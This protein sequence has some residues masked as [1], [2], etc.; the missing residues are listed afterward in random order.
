MRVSSKVSTLIKSVVNRLGHIVPVGK[1]DPPITY[2]IV[3][4]GKNDPPIAPFTMEEGLRRCSKRGIPIETVIDIGASN[5]S[6]TQ[7]CKQFFPDA[8][9]FL[10]EAQ[11]C[12]ENDLKKLRKNVSRTDYVLAAAG[13]R[14]GAIYFDVS[15]PFGGVASDLPFEKDCLEV[16]VTRIDDVVA[17]RA[18]R[19]PY[20]LK[21]DTHG[22][23]I[24][25]LEGAEKTLREAN[26]VILEVYNF[27]IRPEALKFYEICGYMEK[28]GFRPVEIVD[29]MLRQY[30]D[31]FWQ[32]DIFFIRN[33]RKEFLHNGYR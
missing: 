33:D 10:V 7:L 17:A 1:S 32:M 19:P 25:I 20:L 13:S 18:L 31:S 24:P 27:K 15:D 8:Y 16:P 21:L 26:L 12:H 9:Y 2:D 3:P 4:M 23:E 22:F 28:N 11:P 30:D 6:W 14:T 29:L 5:G